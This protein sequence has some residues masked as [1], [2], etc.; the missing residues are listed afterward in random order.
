MSCVL[1]AITQDSDHSLKAVVG[2]RGTCVS[3][4]NWVRLQAEACFGHDGAA[5]DEERLR[6]MC[7]VEQALSAFAHQHQ[8]GHLQGLA[9]VI[10]CAY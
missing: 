1:Q 5:A 2:I 6:L 8:H 7:Q 10:L 3:V 4:L 9:P